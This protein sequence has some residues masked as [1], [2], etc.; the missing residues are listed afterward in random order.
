MVRHFL[1]PG[2]SGWA[3]VNGHRGPTRDTASME[4]RVKADL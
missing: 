4:R 2:I 3:Q 1:M